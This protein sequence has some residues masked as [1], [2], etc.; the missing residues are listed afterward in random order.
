MDDGGRSPGT[1]GRT[2]VRAAS[3]PSQPPRAARSV[4][5]Y[6]CTIHDPPT[7]DRP[8]F[9]HP[10]LVGPVLTGRGGGSGALRVPP[11]QVQ[12]LVVEKDAR[13]W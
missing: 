3:L 8:A 7:P 1:G 5:V 12:K 9:P 10:G 4:S 2:G 6:Q 11:A 13:A